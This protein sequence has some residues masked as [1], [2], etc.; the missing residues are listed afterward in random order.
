MQNTVDHF[1]LVFGDFFLGEYRDIEGFYADDE[2][3]YLDTIGAYDSLESLLDKLYDGN[4]KIIQDVGIFKG[5]LDRPTDH[6]EYDTATKDKFKQQ[7]LSEL[8]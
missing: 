1:V 5:T 3:W 2:T 7:I 8:D 4:N 6:P